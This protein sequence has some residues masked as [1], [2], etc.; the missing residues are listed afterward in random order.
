MDVIHPYPTEL[1]GTYP[2][3]WMILILFEL[4]NGGVPGRECK[5]VELDEI[6]AGVNGHIS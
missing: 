2:R 5:L 4:T 1:G 3:I 6:M